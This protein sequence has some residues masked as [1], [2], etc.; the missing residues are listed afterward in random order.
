M[1]LIAVVAATLLAL[2]LVAADR[3]TCPMHAEHAAAN[4][5]K[6]VDKRGDEAMGFS[7]QATKH[8]FRLF[9]DGGAIEIR[10][11][12][13]GDN[14]TIDA[15]RKRLAEIKKSFSSGDFASPQ[16]IHGKVPD[17]AGFM[18]DSAGAIEY[19]K[20]EVKGGARLRITTKAPEA[21]AAVHHFL[22]FQIDEHRTGDSTAVAPE[23]ER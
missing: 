4:H 7:H 16:F 9:P 20:E 2:P 22:R 3:A 11:T 23:K 21:I 18:K 19:R 6:E 17:G 5:A 1:H 13:E 10:A 15:I 14:R 8:T 12:S